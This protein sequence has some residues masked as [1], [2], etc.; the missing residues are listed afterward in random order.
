MFDI[1]ILQQVFFPI[2][3]YEDNTNDIPI[4][5]YARLNYDKNKC[6]GI[7]NYNTKT[8]NNDQLAVFQAI[9][10]AIYGKMKMKIKIKMNEDTCKQFLFC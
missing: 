3:N 9:E 7:V 8:M 5:L 2:V 1:F 6:A 10:K 4:E